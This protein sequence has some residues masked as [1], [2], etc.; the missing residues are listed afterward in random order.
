MEKEGLIHL[1]QQ[2][3]SSCRSYATKENPLKVCFLSQSQSE[4]LFKFT[5]YAKKNLHFCKCTP[6]PHDIWAYYALSFLFHWLFLTLTYLCLV[7]WCIR[8]LAYW[9]LWK[10][11]PRCLLTCSLQSYPELSSKLLHCS[12]SKLSKFLHW[13]FFNYLIKLIINSPC[14]YWLTQLLFFFTDFNLN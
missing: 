2:Q 13:G 3:Y 11:A 6:G 8:S 5:Y 9:L 7:I 1:S 12:Y 4:L 14:K 10:I